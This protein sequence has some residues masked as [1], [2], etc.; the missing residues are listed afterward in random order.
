MLKQK[1]VY[2]ENFHYINRSSFSLS[3]TVLVCL[4][5][6][7]NVSNR[8]WKIIIEIMSEKQEE[9]N[10]TCQHQERMVEFLRK[11]PILLSKNFTKQFTKKDYDEE[12]AILSR[13]LNAV[14]NHVD[15]MPSDKWQEH[16]KV[17]ENMTKLLHAFNP[18]QCHFCDDLNIIEQKLILINGNLLEFHNEFNE[19][20]QK[21]LENNIHS[22]YI[23]S[24]EDEDFETDL[25]PSKQKKIK[26][27]EEKNV[28]EYE[29]TVA[30]KPIDKK[31]RKS[32]IIMTKPFLK[33]PGS[34]QLK[35]PSKSSVQ[36]VYRGVKECLEESA[37]S[38]KKISDTLTDLLAVTA[39]TQNLLKTVV[40]HDK[41]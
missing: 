2:T 28:I 20:K 12:W 9:T 15:A 36:E 34:P 41:N 16:I 11:Y 3:L 30:P 10:M 24:E 13:I 35:Q 19:N 39:E 5:L 4:S 37:D 22:H 18:N 27:E 38:L 8:F 40:S 25:L 17:I 33:K 14:N 1:T 32:S 7:R 29:K 6:L 23:S 26:Q 21:I 31:K